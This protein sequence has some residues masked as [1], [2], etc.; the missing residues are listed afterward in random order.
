MVPCFGS[1]FENHENSFLKS[2]RQTDIKTCNTTLQRCIDLLTY[3]RIKSSFLIFKTVCV[4]GNHS[5]YSVEELKFS[6]RLNQISTSFWTLQV[7]TTK[8]NSSYFL[9]KSLFWWTLILTSCSW[10]PRVQL[11]RPTGGS[12]S[13]VIIESDNEWVVE[14]GSVSVTTYR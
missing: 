12:Q 9:W 6:F 8:F 5:L 14:H 7:A 13:R 4:A 3:W 1:S 2:V 10:K 11:V